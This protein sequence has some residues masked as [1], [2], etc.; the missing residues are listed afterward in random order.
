MSSPSLGPILTAEA[1]RKADSQTIEKFGISGFTLMETAGRAAVSE[2]ENHVNLSEHTRVVCLCGKGNNGGDGYVIARILANRGIHTTVLSVAPED[3][4]TKD[5]AKNYRLLLQM[6]QQDPASRLHLIHFTN[7]AQL[8]S[9]HKPDVIID[10]L[11]GTGIKS[12]VR[13]PYSDLVKWSNTQPSFTL[14]IDIPS[15]LHADT[16]EVL[17]IAVKADLTV[18]MG[19]HK[20]GLFLGMGYEYTGIKKA[21]EIGIP[22]FLLEN[23]ASMDGCART[24]NHTWIQSRLPQRSFFAHKYSVGMALIVAGSSGLTGAAT[25]ASLSAE[26]SGAGAVVCAAPEDIQPILA[27]KMTE[28]MTL[29]IPSSKNGIEAQKALETLAP[30]L[31]KAR[32]LLIGC[33]MGQLPE[34]QSFIRTLA[35]SHTDC[36]IILDAD[37]LNAFQGH[38][39]LFNKHARGEWILTPHL[40][41]FKRLA[42]DDV[43]LRNLVETVQKYAVSWNCV[44]ILKGAP[45]LVGTPDGS[46]Y[47]NPGVNNALATAGTGDVLAGLCAGLLSQ[48]LSPID[49]AL[50]AL[51]IGLTA[52][53]SYT[54]E[55][56]SSTMRASDLIRHIRIVLSKRYY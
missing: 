17:G 34:T 41:E 29:G 3:K 19:A 33:G 31:L 37:G 14:A 42:G 56:H 5:A 18:S 9:L 25:L 21:V 40:G 38:T 16:G 22:R 8:T 54:T 52:A 11:L 20:S 49:A 15:G 23:A 12:N 28:V 39:H 2:L 27:G 53:N 35:T 26:Q 45:S 13:A 7:P 32:A 48:G 46:V 36:P 1:M 30:R 10:A 24:P 55:F 50:C 43:D 6:V 51:H 44:L 4:L 47:I